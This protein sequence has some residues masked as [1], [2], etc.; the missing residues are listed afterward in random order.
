MIRLV[1]DAAQHRLLGPPRQALD[2][3]SQAAG[4]VAL[5][6]AHRDNGAPRWRPVGQMRAERIRETDLARCLVAAF[7]DAGHAF[8]AIALAR[9][10]PSAGNEVAGRDLGALARGGRGAR[11]SASPPRRST[12]RSPRPRPART[13]G[14]SAADAALALLPLLEAE[15][16]DVVVSDILTLAPALAAE[17]AGLRRATL[18]PHVYPVHE[19]GPAVLRLRRAARRGP[20]VGRGL[21]RRAL[22]VLVGGLRAGAR[23]AQPSR[24]RRSG[25]RR[26]SGFHGG[27]SES[28]ALVATFPQLE[29]PRRWP[30][31]RARDRADGVRAAVSRRRAAGGRRAAG[32]G[33]RRRRRRTP[34]CRLVRVA[35]EA[36]ADEPVRV[37]ATTNRP[38]PDGAA[39]AGAGE[40]AWWSTGSA[41]RRRW[42]SPTW[43]SAT[44]ATGRSRGRSAPACRCSAVPAV[45]DM[46]ENGRPRGLVGRRADAAVAAA[47]APGRCGWRCARRSP[48]RRWA[49]GRPRSGAGRRR[50]TAPS[51]ARSWSRSW[52]SAVSFDGARGPGEAG[53]AG[54]AAE[55]GLL[56]LRVVAC[57]PVAAA[58]S[59]RSIVELARSLCECGAPPSFF[60]LAAASAA[61]S[62]D[63]AVLHTTTPSRSRCLPMN[64]ATRDRPGSYL[65]VVNDG[66]VTAASAAANRASLLRMPCERGRDRASASQTCP[67]S[68]RRRFGDS[69][70]PARRDSKPL[71]P[72][73]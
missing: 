47:R 52:R 71:R 54:G 46:A 24:G 55:L 56:D 1:V 16:F 57:R 69:S 4:G 15:R 53:I 32:A 37:L 6:A 58:R 19:A 27:I 3:E 31:A 18:I 42:R 7:G 67:G 41:T 12:R 13:T 59:P 49:H 30:A 2:G 33:R 5:T 63:R 44:A 8:P 38:R 36:L 23:R 17:R 64:V 21:W 51:A 73:G 11:A 26:S 66:R 70:D 65:N 10:L 60:D 14:P 25:W 22:P 48:R 34:T 45:G 29:Y 35:L 28:L 43:S 39:A 68:R 20:P 72:I 62:F 40:R 61:N 50:T 9:A